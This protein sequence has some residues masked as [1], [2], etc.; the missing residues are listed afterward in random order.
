MRNKIW[1][2]IGC[3]LVGSIPA[4]SNS[5]SKPIDMTPCFLDLKL[6]SGSSTSLSKKGDYVDFL[7]Y[8]PVSPAVGNRSVNNH[9]ILKFDI[10]SLDS[11]VTKAKITKEYFAKG[12]DPWSDRKEDE[13]FS[14]EW[15]RQGF[16]YDK[17]NDE[18]HFKFKLKKDISEFFTINMQLLDDIIYFQNPDSGWKDSEGRTKELKL[19]FHPVNSDTSG[20]K[21]GEISYTNLSFDSSAFLVNETEKKKALSSIANTLKYQFTDK[22]ALPEDK[23]KA[24]WMSWLNSIIKSEKYLPLLPNFVGFLTTY[25]AFNFI[26]ECYNSNRNVHLYNYEYNWTTKSGF[27]V[28]DNKT[29]DESFIKNLN[30][31]INFKDIVADDTRHDLISSDAQVIITSNPNANQKNEI[32]GL[33]LDKNE[34][35]EE[36]DN[37]PS[38]Y[39]HIVGSRGLGLSITPTYTAHSGVNSEVVHGCNFEIYGGVI[40]STMHNT[41]DIHNPFGFVTSGCYNNVGL[42]EF[43][44]TIFPNIEVEVK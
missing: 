7:I 33:W 20:I 5:C 12:F 27:I 18:W 8:E 14:A 40:E 29:L 32:E 31:Q 28:K 23:T 1:K 9:N 35:D 37:N 24:G 21:D 22:P 44:K 34:F 17:E 41:L 26:Y 6:L 42:S 10:F 11:S 25:N 43:I 38:L 13:D 3:L 4:I 15:P 19:E 36:L 16:H 30:L 39:S 2:F